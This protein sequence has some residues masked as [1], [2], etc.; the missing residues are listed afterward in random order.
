M[1]VVESNDHYL[2]ELLDKLSKE[3][4]ITFFL[5]D[6]HSVHPSP[7]A[8]YSGGRGWGEVEPSIKFSKRWDLT[9]S[10]FLEGQCWERGGCLFSGRGGGGCSFY[11]K[12]KVKSEMLN[13]KKVYKEENVFLCLN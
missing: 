4:E 3:N 6:L 1:N 13:N 11:I 7:H 12:S 8:S 9:G 2:I 10:Q 5:G